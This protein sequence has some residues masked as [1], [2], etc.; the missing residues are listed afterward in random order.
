MSDEVLTGKR[1]LLA[2]GLWLLAAVVIGTATAFAA[3]SIGA[4]AVTAIVPEETLFR[5]VLV[6]VAPAAASGQRCDP[7]LCRRTCRDPW[8]PCD[9]SPRFRFR[10]RLRLGA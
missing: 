9:S 1:V 3:R 7:R 2:L 4:A 8:L 6:H 5:G 10:A